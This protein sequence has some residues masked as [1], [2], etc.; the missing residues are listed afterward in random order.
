MKKNCIYVII[1]SLFYGTMPLIVKQI[2]KLG[3]NAQMVVNLRFLFSAIFLLI[4]FFITKK[5]FYLSKKQ[6]FQ[7]LVFG[8]SGYGFTGLLLT[9]SYQYLSS[10]MA[11]VF[12]FIAPLF[13]NLILFVIFKE[14]PTLKI[15]LSTCCA[16]VGMIMIFY[17]STGI[18]TK[19][20]LLAAS[21]GFT[22]A[23]YMVSVQKSDLKRID[24][25]IT[26][27][28]ITLSSGILFSII[29]LFQ[30]NFV[31]PSNLSA[32]G[33]S[34]LVALFCGAIPMVLITVSVQKIGSVKT[35]TLNMLEPITSV[36]LGTVL[37]H[38][39]MNLSIFLGIVIVLFSILQVVTQKNT[40]K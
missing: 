22:Y 1:A 14:K 11:T 15:I 37:L 40:Q 25:L 32:L 4:Y 23:V 17:S 39:E 27:F 36:I 18:S 21:S 26:V 38:D 31:F 30:G 34:L 6:L 20:V 24:S 28:Y 7:V 12:H 3:L 35:S 19:G 13:V 5:K 2:L 9:L 33:L 16:V 8:V 29:S 10:G